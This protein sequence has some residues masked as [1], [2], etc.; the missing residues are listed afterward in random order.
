[1]FIMCLW[2][3]VILV[4]VTKMFLQ[5]FHVFQ[6][7]SSSTLVAQDFVDQVIVGHT[8]LQVTNNE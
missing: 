7:K 6:P 1:M 5:T 4:Y 8:K 2:P 3:L